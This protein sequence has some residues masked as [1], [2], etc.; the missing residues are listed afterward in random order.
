[1]TAKT[2]NFSGLLYY[3]P[4]VNGF[5]PIVEATVTG[6]TSINEGA[7][8][9]FNA[10]AWGIPDGP[11]YWWINGLTNITTDRIAPG[12]AAEAT[13]LNNRSSFTVEVSANNATAPGAQS[14]TINFGK[15]QNVALESITVS[16]A[17][18]SQG[19]PTYE[20]IPSA[21]SMD[22]GGTG[23]TFTINTTGLAD[24]T[25]VIWWIDG[26]G[27]VVDTAWTNRFVEGV[28]NGTVTIINNTAS[29]T[30]TASSNDTVGNG[31]V[32]SIWISGTLFQ[33]V[34]NS[35]DITINDIVPV[36]SS[37]IF[38]GT[39]DY[40]EVLGTT[41]DWALGTTWT[42]EYWSKHTTVSG[43]GTIYTVL[44]QNFDGNGIDLYYQ[45]GN[46]LI[47]NGRTLFAE[48]TPGVWTHVA[49]V[50]DAGTLTLYYNGTSVYTGAN[51]NLGNTTNTL[52]IGKRGPGTFQYFLGKLT[53]IR[54]T[55]T[56][57][58]TS[59]FDPYT[60]ARIPTKIAGTRL[61]MNP[62]TLAYNLDLSD[63]AHTFS[64]STG[65]GD[66]YP[67]H[68]FIARKYG[69]NTGYASN[70]GDNGI[71]VLVADYPD[72]VNV[73]SGATVTWGGNTPGTIT[74]LESFT[75]DG[76]Q[77]FATNTL[78]FTTWGNDTLTFTW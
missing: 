43:P 20:I 60:V 57:V 32:F 59:A 54:I 17:D 16:V 26:I 21:T 72:I 24:N 36:P 52:M 4:A 61:L 70:Q 66:D 11:M 39:S 29:F 58:Y 14:Y 75:Q 62:T 49:L 12:L 69:V 50:N 63:S 47:N 42:M 35:G 3:N 38:N 28:N 10:V 22:E 18:T 5:N 51:W 71:S 6:P 55:N 8:A 73:P 40:K 65:G 25:Q 64:G 2:T 23:I 44:C 13:I 27:S 76:I 45:G 1:M 31:A 19:Q 67:P 34:A 74:V 30:L 56:A 77:R 78:S 37:L 15:V 53:G 7:T 46:L 48:P 68:R 9:T 41:S 33:G